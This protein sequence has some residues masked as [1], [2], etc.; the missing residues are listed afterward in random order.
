MKTLFFNLCALGPNNLRYVHRRKL[1]TTK[2][3]YKDP[4]EYFLLYVLEKRLFRQEAL[5]LYHCELMETIFYNPMY[6]DNISIKLV[7]AMRF[8]VLLPFFC[9]CTLSNSL[10]WLIE[11]IFDPY[12]GRGRVIPMQNHAKKSYVLSSVW[13]SRK[14]F[15]QC[16]PNYTKHNKNN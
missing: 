5:V 13:C 3:F 10:L 1:T 7:I 14:Q 9:I 12:H 4:I 6:F 16:Y 11:G 2:F 15:E 8:L